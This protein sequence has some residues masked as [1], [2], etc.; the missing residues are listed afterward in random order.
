M[1]KFWVFRTVDSLGILNG[2]QLFSLSRQELTDVCFQEG[3]KV[4]SFVT[5]QKSLANNNNS[6][7][8]EVRSSKIVI[9]CVFSRRFMKWNATIL[10]TF[11]PPLN[12]FFSRHCSL[13]T[14]PD[15]Y[16][17]TFFR[18]RKNVWLLMQSYLFPPDLSMKIWIWLSAV[19]WRRSL[20]ES[21]I[22]HHSGIR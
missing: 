3:A 17:D 4:F 22:Q 18:S 14:V 10:V 1:W 11:P 5:V 13:E 21:T 7:S 20:M 19:W 2:A 15:S 6:T 8:T 9:S 12:V 16:R